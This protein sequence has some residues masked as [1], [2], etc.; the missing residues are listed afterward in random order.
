MWGTKGA[1]VP[2]ALFVLWLWSRWAS[3]D[4]STENGWQKRGLPCQVLK[5]VTNLICSA[6]ASPT[7]EIVKMHFE[8]VAG[9][10]W[11]TTERTES[12]GNA[13]QM[14]EALGEERGYISGPPNMRC[15]QM[16]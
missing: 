1:A 5:L 4:L 13:E 16:I 12:E 14:Q 9:S 3:A 11:M 2:P 6:L 7:T 8:F 15:T 10:R